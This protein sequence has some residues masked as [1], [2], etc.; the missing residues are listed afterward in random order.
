MLRA[1]HKDTCTSR[2]SPPSGPHLRAK[3][4]GTPE[5]VAAYLL[6]IAEEVRPA[7]GRRSG[8][9]RSTRPSAGSSA[10]A[11]GSTGDARADAMDLTPLLAAAGR[12]PRRPA[13]SSR[14][15]PSSGPARPSATGCWPTPSS[16]DLGRR[17]HRAGATRSPTPTAPSAPPS[18]GPSP[19]SAASTPPRGTA[20]V[21]LHRLGRARASA[22][23]WPTASSSSSTARPTTTSARA[24]AAGA[25]SIRPP[26]R[27]RR[28]SPVLAGNTCLYG[29]TGG[30][31]FVAGA[32]G[33]RFARAQLGRHRRGRGRGRPRVRVHDRR[34]RR[35]PRPRRL[36][37]RRRHDRRPGLRLGPRRAAS[38]PGS[39]PPWSRPS[40]PTP[41]RSRSCAGW[42]S[43]T[44]ELTGSPRA[45]ELLDDWD[46]HRRRTSGTSRPSTGSGASSRP[47]RAGS[48]TPDRSSGTDGARTPSVA[49]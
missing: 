33:E 19:S 9:G 43:A 2:A 12:P 36:Q 30:E 13:A 45:G 4:A 3:F 11:S 31:L 7:A 38:P 6:F 5:G 48:P 32:V 21:P 47:T 24:W 16:A 37:P 15:S 41:S 22:P 28:R 14:R 1:C 42:S 17:R 10:C 49:P 34:H 23:S 40:G 46:G 39:T 27:R 26:G 18:A 44:C 35:R 20:T 8:C 29:A 25:S